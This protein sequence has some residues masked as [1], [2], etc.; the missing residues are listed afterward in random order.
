MLVFLQFVFLTGKKGSQATLVSYCEGSSEKQSSPSLLFTSRSPRK[1]IRKRNH[2]R[3][4]LESILPA[5]SLL[6]DWSG[7]CYKC[8]C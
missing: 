1:D 4:I 7:P 2:G 3:A 8:I 5:I 6:T